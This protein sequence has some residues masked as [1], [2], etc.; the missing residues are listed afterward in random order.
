ME[1]AVTVSFGARACHRGAP[2]WLETL[3]LPM[4]PVRASPRTGVLFCNEKAK[5][6]TLGGGAFFGWA[7]ARDVPGAPLISLGTPRKLQKKKERAAA[8]FSMN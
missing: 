1:P 4:P 8:T 6:P 5:A 3:T 2:I 7:E